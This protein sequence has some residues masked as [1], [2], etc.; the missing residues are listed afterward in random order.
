LIID[1]RTGCVSCFRLDGVA[2]ES[3][4]VGRGAVRRQDAFEDIATRQVLGGGLD[5]RERPGDQA[6][7]QVQA[8]PDID[9]NT[10]RGGGVNPSAIAGQALGNGDREIGEA[11]GAELEGVPIEVRVEL[12]GDRDDFRWG[13]RCRLIFS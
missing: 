3:F 12:L 9:V 5:G 11:D 13:G 6:G 2:H 4:S 1:D 10:Q 8:G 7:L